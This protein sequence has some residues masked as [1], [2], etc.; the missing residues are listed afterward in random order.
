LIH[1]VYLELLKGHIHDN[2]FG[3]HGM[4]GVPLTT[5]TTTEAEHF[6][7]VIPKRFAEDYRK[8]SSLPEEL[9]LASYKRRELDSYE[10]GLDSY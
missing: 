9:K 2:R 5:R 7:E 4:R 10:R 8:G 3:Y 1:A 6:K